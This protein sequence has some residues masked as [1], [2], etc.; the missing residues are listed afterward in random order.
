MENG[1]GVPSDC[2]KN[3]SLPDGKSG[4]PD[5]KEQLSGNTKN[6]KIENDKESMTQMDR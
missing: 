1:N 6:T 4:F 2:E 3:E 5:D